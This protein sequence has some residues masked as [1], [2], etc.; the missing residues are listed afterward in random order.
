MTP[1]W[2]YNPAPDLEEGIAQR[3][4]RF[5]RE[6]TMLTYG[7]RSAAALVLRA[8]LRTYHRLHIIGRAN[9]HSRRESFRLVE[10]WMENRILVELILEQDLEDAIAALK[11]D[12]FDRDHQRLGYDLTSGKI[13]EKAE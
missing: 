8:W 5:P 13:L 1:T 2:E 11:V 4:A 7:A 3:L 12:A 9:Y 10:F 6:P